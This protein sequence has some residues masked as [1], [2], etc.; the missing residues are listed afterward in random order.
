MF[1]FCGIRLYVL[2]LTDDNDVSFDSFWGRIGAMLYTS[3]AL[4]TALRVLSALIDLKRPD[5]ADVS[6]LRRLAPHD[7]DKPI[8]E[9]ACEVIQ[10][11]VRTR[12]DRINRSGKRLARIRALRDGL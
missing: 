4:K 7:A 12:I 1:I 11:A 5:P 9:P 8:D 2:V 10:K 6:E 3:T